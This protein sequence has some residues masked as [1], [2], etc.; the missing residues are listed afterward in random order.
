MS[1]TNRNFVVTKKRRSAL[2][3][4]FILLI[5]SALSI[6]V[7]FFVF[8]DRE[9]TLLQFFQ[10]QI[11]SHF[12]QSIEALKVMEDKS[13]ELKVLQDFAGKASDGLVQA[14]PSFIALGAFITALI[15]YYVTRFLWRRIDSHDMFHQARFSG[16]VVPDQVVWVLIASS[17]AFFLAENAL[18]FVG[19]NLLLISLVAYFFQGLAIIIYFLESRNV[20]VFFWVLI[21]FVILFQPLLVGV[22]IGLG[23]FDNWID[24]RKIRVVE[25]R[26]SE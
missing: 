12:T 10:K 9:A 18:G 4:T 21:F 3:F 7:L 25:E 20:P 6:A 17:A 14:Y 22:S 24:L 19:I 5:S 26:S 8:V 16:W 15:N 2:L 11:D 1:V 23:I 13:E